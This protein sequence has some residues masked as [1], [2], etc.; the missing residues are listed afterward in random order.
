MAAA[1][2][3]AGR[4]VCDA[5]LSCVQEIV[6]VET[7]DVLAGSSFPSDAA[8]RSMVT[9]AQAPDGSIAS[10]PIRLG[11]QASFGVPATELRVTW[12]DGQA[13]E[14]TI[15]NPRSAPVWLP[16]SDQLLVLTGLGLVKVEQADGALTA[17]RVR[18]LNVRGATALFVLR[19]SNA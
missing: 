15:D 10:L 6:D 12:R 9:M 16:G 4:V 17:T 14:M 18:D 1:D 11:S 5:A 19:D 7:G 13:M 2:K 3:Y 8:A